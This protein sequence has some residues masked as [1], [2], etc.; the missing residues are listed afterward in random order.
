[1]RLLTLD[2]STSSSG[3]ALF[4][5]GKL[6]SYGVITPRVKGISKLKY[7]MN[8][9]RKIISVA[10]GV[11]R[12][13]TESKPDKIYIEEVN[14]GIS[15]IS[16]KS[17]DAL[18]YFVLLNLEL[19]NEYSK[20]RYIDSDGQTG[21]RTILGLRLSKAEKDANKKRKK[22]KKIT[23]KHLACNYVN[24]AL[25]TSFDVDKNP[26]DSDRVDAIGLGLSVYKAGLLDFDP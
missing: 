17:L 19:E 18:H 2:L 22:G 26:G 14:R 8:S 15:R 13:V 11:K 9:L 6:L 10:T 1:M 20:L 7:P 21:W 5:D 3:F 12:I 25:G 4:E 16:Q 23:K 24:A